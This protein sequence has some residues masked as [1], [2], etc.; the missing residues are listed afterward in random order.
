MK[1]PKNHAPKPPTVPTSRYKLSRH[2]SG[3]FKLHY[4]LNSK[5]TIQERISFI[6]SLSRW[7][8][9]DSLIPIQDYNFIILSGFSQ[10]T[11]T[12]HLIIQPVCYTLK[13]CDFMYE[14]LISILIN[15]RQS[16]VSFLKKDYND[17]I[18]NYSA[19]FISLAVMVWCLFGDW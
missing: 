8:R 12:N 17:N 19:L 16:N 6:V 7:L 14:E 15:W 11:M 5:Y 18:L 3:K 1:V 10:S 2:V 13:Q 4:N 9:S